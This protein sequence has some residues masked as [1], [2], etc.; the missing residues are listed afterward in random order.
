MLNDDQKKQL[1]GALDFASEKDD[2]GLTRAERFAAALDPLI[3][4]QMRMG[5]QIRA[6]GA[7]RMKKEGTNK[8]VEWLKSNGYAEIA[9]MVQTNP[10][11]ASNVM[12]AIIAKKINPPQA[13]AKGQVVSAIELRKMYP[14]ENIPDG[15]YNISPSGNITKVGGG[16]ST[17]NINMPDQAPAEDKLREELMKKQGKDFGAYL[18]AGSAASQAM[19]DLRVLQELAPLAP[20]GP[21]TGRLAQAFPEFNDVATLRQSIVNR[22]APTLRVEGSG[23]T[24]DLEFNAMLASLG[25]LKNTPEAN[26]AIIS[27][28][29]QKQ[30]YNLDRAN[31]VRQYQTGQILLQD[32]NNAL[33]ALEGQSTIPAA[34][35]SIL[36]RYSGPNASP[37]SSP[38]PKVRT[39][40]PETQEFE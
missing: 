25:S 9:A 1:V 21:I 12:S 40:N 29:M 37:A 7:S 2:D 4:P 24:S 6:T 13:K 17:T 34:V 32:A 33:A 30:Q 19:T 5:E 10:A 22:V 28:M 3:L 26:Q 31:I 27:V 16:G 15:L 38:Q 39:W 11:I 36:Q 8:T 35:Q 23:A 20:S 14:G 18:D